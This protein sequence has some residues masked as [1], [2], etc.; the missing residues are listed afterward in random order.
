MPRRPHEV[1]GLGRAEQDG[2][3]SLVGQE[4]RG[5]RRP[6]EEAR[7]A[8]RLQ[9]GPRARLHGD[10]RRPG[11]LQGGERGGLRPFVV[12]QVPRHQHGLRGHVVREVGS[13]QAAV[14]TSIR[15]HGSLVGS[16]DHQHG[17]GP[18]LLVEGEAGLNAS[19]GERVRHDAAERVVADPPDQRDTRSLGR[20]PDRRVRSAPARPDPDVAVDIAAPGQSARFHA[21]V[22]HHVTDDDDAWRPH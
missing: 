21:D 22:H 2:R 17:P 1:L 9:Q 7:G 13:T 12:E 18:G 20:R 15:H 5:A 3:L 4:Q 10:Q 8:I 19:G 14:R 16:V 6:L 11:S